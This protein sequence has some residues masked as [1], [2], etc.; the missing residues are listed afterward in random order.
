[1]LLHDSYTTAIG[2]LYDNYNIVKT[3]IGNQNFD[4][5]TGT[6]RHDTSAARADNITS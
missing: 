1:M 4:H 6:G 2:Y 3:A 5:M